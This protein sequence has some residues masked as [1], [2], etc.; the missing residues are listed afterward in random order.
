MYEINNIIE[1]M[2]DQHKLLQVDLVGALNVAKGENPNISEMSQGLK[3]F[4]DD[5]SDHLSLENDTFYPELLKRMK[6][7]GLDI[8]KTEIFINQMKDIGVQVITFLEKYSVVSSID[9]QLEDFKRELT[10]IISILNLRIESEES[11]VYLYWES[12]K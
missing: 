2:K 5:L 11:G 8:S 10:N 1:K 7:K 12:Y 6:D 4:N 3:K 9:T